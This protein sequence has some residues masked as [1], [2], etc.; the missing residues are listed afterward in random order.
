[1]GTDL[2]QSLMTVISFLT[3]LAIVIW[4]YS[5]AQKPRFEQ[6]ARLPFEEDELRKGS[7]GELP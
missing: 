1:M 4:A 6:A 3:F 5:A 7:S 2:F